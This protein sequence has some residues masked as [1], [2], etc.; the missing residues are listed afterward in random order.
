MKGAKK[1][2]TC[3]QKLLVEKMG[4]FAEV[5]TGKLVLHLV[6]CYTQI[7]FQSKTIIAFK[8]QV[9]TENKPKTFFF[10]S[11]YRRHLKYLNTYNI[12]IKMKYF[13]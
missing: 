9:E 1:D 3:N 4:Y 13:D 10:A 5:T 8:T 6:C 12:Y 2:F 11:M 7:H